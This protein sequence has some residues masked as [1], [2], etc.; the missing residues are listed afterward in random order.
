MVAPARGQT[1]QL[2]R[3][4]FHF[5]ICEPLLLYQR[6]SYATLGHEHRSV[7]L[8]I[9]VADIASINRITLALIQIFLLTVLSGGFAVP[10]YLAEV[11]IGAT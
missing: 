6:T 11:Y 2:L 9:E 5:R 10:R 1:L 3:S 7:D 4:F 8:G